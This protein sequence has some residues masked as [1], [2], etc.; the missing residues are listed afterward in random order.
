MKK[1]W[2][3]GIILLL[4]FVYA[5]ESE[6]FFITISPQKQTVVAGETAVYDLTILNDGIN[7]QIFEV[8]S[9]DVIWDVK[10]DS[11]LFVGGKQELR[12]K[13]LISPLSVNSG[14]YGVPVVV[15]KVGVSES[16][17]QTVFFELQSNTPAL[18]SYL[19]AF[20]GNA[21]MP[22]KIEPGKEA[23][24]ALTL[25][26]L[27]RRNLSDVSVK[28]R[29]VILNKDY[30]TALEPRE[31]KALSF[32]VVVGKS[33]APQKDVLRIHLIKTENDKS[34]QYEVQPLE[35]EIVAVENVV[36][37]EFS[38]D[39]FFKKT[40]G[41]R[42]KNN[43]NVPQ[44]GVFAKKMNF[45]KRLFSQASPEAEVVKGIY[46]WSVPLDVSEE[47]TVSV[48]TNYRPVAFTI[49]T[50]LLVFVLYLVF[51]SPLH[52]R[53]TAGI[54]STKE[55]GISELKVR[56]NIKNRSRRDIKNI[57]LIDLVPKIADVN[58]HFESSA[59]A[60][61]EIVKHDKRGTLLKWTINS[62]DV[63]EEYI[64]SY[65]MT[66]KFSILGGTTLPVAVAKFVDA[67]GRERT[68]SSN[69]FKVKLQK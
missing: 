60:P 42:I 37:S 31:R 23:T 50:A 17:K 12:T 47:R 49:I 21:S 27:N 53:K 32:S 14:L 13:L 39:E 3:V 29:S 10:T 36:V 51:R 43:G 54:V 25:E 15:R 64:L 24:I 5:Q 16:V 7:S 65:R 56:L 2:W 67:E 59:S 22:K 38:E 40:V 9:P 6:T 44:Q 46:S 41:A 1:V 52:I 68:T 62:L 55:G 30:V 61:S 20:R 45:F 8:Y 28:V 48:V 19:P 26:N 35:Y 4:Q 58:R 57:N 18:M 63:G 11:S 69:K 33:V 34:Y 66:S